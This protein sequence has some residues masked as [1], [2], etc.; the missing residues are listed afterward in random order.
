MIY[1]D[2]MVRE[3]TELALK[4]RRNPTKDTI[5]DLMLRMRKWEL[6]DTKVLFW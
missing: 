2:T 5:T 6:D 4:M 1:A 3:K